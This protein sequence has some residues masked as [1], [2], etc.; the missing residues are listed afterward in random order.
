MRAPIRYATR[1]YSLQHL[2]H[3]GKCCERLAQFL[4]FGLILLV[5]PKINLQ[6]LVRKSVEEFQELRL[7]APPILSIRV[8]QA[9]G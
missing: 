5:A 9:P 8:H 2:H 3:F 4:L 6:V 1:V 7:T